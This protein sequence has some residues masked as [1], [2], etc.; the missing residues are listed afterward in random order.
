M[1]LNEFLEGLVLSVSAI[2]MLKDSDE[3]R[4]ME[5]HIVELMDEHGAPMGP[6][7]FIVTALPPDEVLSTLSLFQSNVNGPIFTLQNVKSGA[8]RN[9]FYT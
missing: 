2:Q 1:A 6:E 3:Q 4:G 7:A 8:G 5:L 9:V